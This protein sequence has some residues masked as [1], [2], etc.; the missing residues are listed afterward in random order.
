MQK[1]LAIVVA[2]AFAMTA[3]GAQATETINANYSI[4]FGVDFDGLPEDTRDGIALIACTGPPEEELCKDAGIDAIGGFAMYPEASSASEIVIT[5]SDDNFDATFVEACVYVGA[6]HIQCGGNDA[7]GE[8]ADVFAG[9]CGSFSVQGD[10]Q[11]IQSIAGFVYTAH[12]DIDTIET[13]FGSSGSASA[14]LS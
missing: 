6:P 11:E 13:C 8:F 3:V 7:E 9:G 10:I 1:I 5:V 4:A 2:T 14:V 12:L